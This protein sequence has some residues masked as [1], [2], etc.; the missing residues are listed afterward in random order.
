M[1]VTDFLAAI[2]VGIS[3]DGTELL[4]L[5]YGEDSNAHVDM[6]IVMTGEGEFVEVQGTGEE[7]TFTSDQLQKML[8]LASGGLKNKWNPKGSSWGCSRQY[9]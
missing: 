6:N 3:P 9:R 8:G 1:P 7:A 4:D 2:S 5:D